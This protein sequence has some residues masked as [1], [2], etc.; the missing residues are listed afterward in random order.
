MVM[1]VGRL[2]G[3]R[4]I[5]TGAGSGIGRA[6]AQRFAREGARVALVE[7][8]Q[9]A[10]A[11]VAGQIAAA[12]GTALALTTDVARED[13]IERAVAAAVA[14]WGGLDVVVAVAGI[15]LF[16]QGD[17]RVDR[18]E[19]AVWQQI[20]DVNLT[21]MFLTCKHGVRALLRTGGGSVIVT[22][23]PTGL[24][25]GAL[26]EHAY[27][28]S[29]AGCHGL[30]RVMANEYARDGIRVNVVIPGFIDTPLNAPVFADPAG[31]AAYCESIPARRPGQP[32]EIAAMNVWLASDEASYAIGGFFVVDGGQ[33]AV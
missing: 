10:L 23:S 19:L 2:A 7:R 18:L 27:S 11:E 21:G 24:Y 28:A 25:G 20:L 26:G 4:A 5:V 3:K 33:T 9:P 13:E 6:T 1:P 30:A 16:G 22:G 32:E 12:G 15:E 8:R 14:A 17:D 31:V 29:K